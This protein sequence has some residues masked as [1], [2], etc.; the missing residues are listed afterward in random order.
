MFLVDEL[1]HLLKK[2]EN[3]EDLELIADTLQSFFNSLVT[4]VK[5]AVM[6]KKLVDVKRPVMEKLRD[7]I[8]IKEDQG[9]KKYLDKLYEIR[10]IDSLFDDFLLKYYFISYLNYVLL[11]DISKVA[12]NESIAKLFDEYEMVYVKL[13]SKATFKSLM[14]VFY[15]CPHLKPTAPIGLPKVLF[16]LND[17]WQDRTILDWFTT[18][19]SK[20][21]WF[22]WCLLDKL[23]KKCIVV[24][25]A[26][27]PSVLSD[28]LECLK[29]SA[30][31]EMF[32]KNGMCIGLPD[33]DLPTVTC[34]GKSEGM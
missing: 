29:S 27:F 18:F 7:S 11:K 20:F 6:S 23:R 24:T 25:Y 1:S 2:I 30:V 13:I 16:H 14:S 19:F 31:E 22:E 21:S 12:D 9:M 5:D 17:L 33:L 34:P 15:R 4:K 32:E 26:I 10:D 8:C 28:A 3:T